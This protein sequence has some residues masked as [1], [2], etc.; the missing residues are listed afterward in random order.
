M[1][2]VYGSRLTVFC[3]LMSCVMS[4]IF[5]DVDFNTVNRQRSTVNCFIKEV[6]IGKV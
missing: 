6:F 2:T 4:K 5:F 1:A 3:F